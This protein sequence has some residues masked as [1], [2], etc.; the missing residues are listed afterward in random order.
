MNA[1]DQLAGVYM[2]YLR[3]ASAQGDFVGYHSNRGV[4]LKQ[5][6]TGNALTAT[7]PANR[8]R[9]SRYVYA[10]R[11]HVG[12]ERIKTPRCPLVCR[13]SNAER[14]VGCRRLARRFPRLTA[15]WHR[16]GSLPEEM[17]SCYPRPADG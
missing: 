3:E 6:P 15:G 7:L 11:W 17:S 12:G 1:V 5:I 13:A 4:R 8:K 10:F 2:N 9:P 16:E 14:I